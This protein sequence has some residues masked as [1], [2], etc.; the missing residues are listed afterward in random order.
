MGIFSTRS[1]WLP[2]MLITLVASFFGAVLARRGRHLEALQR[3]KA[4]L[5][6]ELRELE[7][8]NTLLKERRDALLSSPQAIERVAR[9][10]YGFT[11]PGESVIVLDSPEQAPEGAAR[12]MPAAK[13][14]IRW[15]DAW[16]IVPAGVFAVTASLFALFNLLG[17][18][19]TDTG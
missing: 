13:T 9:E 14:W 6:Q 17:A 12:P 15:S 16:F 18:R 4:R 11:A 10:E 3:E 19:R 1:F 2:V 7:A 5:E 8:E